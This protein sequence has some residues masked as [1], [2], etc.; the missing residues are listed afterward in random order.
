MKWAIMYLLGYLVGGLMAAFWKSGVL[1]S[2]G[3][4]LFWAALGFATATC[5]GITL[6]SAR[7]RSSETV[8][9]DHT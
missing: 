2:A 8:T 4:L 5:L 6:A 9:I 1:H 7:R 3:T